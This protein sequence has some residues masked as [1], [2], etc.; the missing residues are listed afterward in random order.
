MNLFAISW[1]SVDLL[2]YHRSSMVIPPFSCDLHD[3]QLKWSKKAK[4]SFFRKNML[5]CFLMS[6]S[7]QFNSNESY[8]MQHSGSSCLCA[9]AVGV[10][11]RLR[12]GARS[13]P[14]LSVRM[15]HPDR[16][17]TVTAVQRRPLLH[18]SQRSALWGLLGST[19][20]SSFSQVH[21]PLTPQSG[22]RSLST[23]YGLT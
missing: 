22:Q 12:V 8:S 4:F 20:F 19:C 2:S 10:M 3:N 17:P 21:P 23:L 6:V 1:K 9:G 18:R 15:P 14:L 11:F 16:R 13:I 7:R 5:F